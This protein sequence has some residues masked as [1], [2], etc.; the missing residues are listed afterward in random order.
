MFVHCACPR[1]WLWPT[2]FLGSAWHWCQYATPRLKSCAH[3]RRQADQCTSRVS[4]FRALVLRSQFFYHEFAPTSQA[5]RSIVV[6]DIYVSKLHFRLNKQMT[7]FLLSITHCS[8]ALYAKNRVLHWHIPCVSFFVFFRPFILICHETR[9]GYSALNVLGT[10][11]I[12]PLLLVSRENMRNVDYN[13]T[14]I[15]MIRPFSNYASSMRFLP[16][17]AKKIG[18]KYNTMKENFLLKW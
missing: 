2:K 5:F 15:A 17:S 6:F 8:S 16:I 1:T 9:M 4:F 11:W 3:K 7:F 14:E 18:R 10:A 13:K 12:P